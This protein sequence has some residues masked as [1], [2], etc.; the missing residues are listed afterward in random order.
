MD[1]LFD[2]PGEFKE[3][4]KKE[5]K[6]ITIFNKEMEMNRGKYR[7]VNISD[8]PQYYLEYIINKWDLTDDEEEL[9][10]EYIN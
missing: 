10:K 3:T 5:K 2:N 8:V 9:I 1:E 6:E 7:G 4:Q